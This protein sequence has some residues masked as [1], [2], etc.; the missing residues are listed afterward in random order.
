MKKFKLPKFALF[1]GKPKKLQA[2]TAARRAPTSENY[3]EEE[4]KTNLSSAFIVVLVLHVVAVGG[5]Y[6]FNSL[7][8]SRQPRTSQTS[9]ST[10]SSIGAALPAKTSAPIPAPESSP[11]KSAAAPISKTNVYQV[12]SGDT[13]TKIAAMKGVSV[14][15]LEEANA[16]KAGVILRP[17][18]VLTIPPARI[19]PK[20]PAPA[21]VQDSRK[22][23]FLSTRA[24]STPAVSATAN[25]ATRSYTVAKGDTPTSIAKKFGTTSTDLLKLNK[26]D[27]PK[28]MQIGQTLKV[29]VKKN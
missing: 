24:E 16:I 15:D 4:P 9:E 12:Q 1:A 20:I 18:Q 5:I 23:A 3:Y 27:D 6:A 8:A 29:P 17:N 10:T 13:L 26:I 11:G 7:R 25:T 22:A 28:K 14:A 2:T 21:V 19:A